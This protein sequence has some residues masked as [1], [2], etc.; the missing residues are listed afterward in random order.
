L[1]PHQLERR[2]E[3]IGELA[4]FLGIQA[5]YQRHQFGMSE[6]LVPEKLPHMR[7]VL[8]LAVRVVVNVSQRIGRPLVHLPVPVTFNLSQLGVA[9]LLKFYLPKYL[10]VAIFRATHEIANPCSFNHRLGRATKRCEV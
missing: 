3:V 9:T 6:A 7:P 8:L 1:P 5:V 2:L 4:P 10:W